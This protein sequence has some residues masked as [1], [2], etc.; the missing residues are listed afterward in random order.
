M[1]ELQVL[2]HLEDREELDTK[3][4]EAKSTRQILIDEIKI[5]LGLSIYK[6]SILIRHV[7]R[8]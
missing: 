1:K 3:T 6:L 4:I 5:F 8:H 7:T 2:T